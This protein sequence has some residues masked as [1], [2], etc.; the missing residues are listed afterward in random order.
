MPVEVDSAVESKDAELSPTP[1]LTSTARDSLRRS[2][3]A[4]GKRPWRP[5]VTP[6]QEVQTHK[7]DGSGTEED[8]FVVTW[9]PG[10][11]AEDPFEFGDNRK[12]FFLTLAGF[13]TMGVSMGSSIY[14]AGV[15]DIRKHLAGSD[16]DYILRGSPASE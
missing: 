15:F 4:L 7:F 3:K 14:S 16:T 12:W 9:L 8:P 11:D 13:S 6:W 5:Y 1:S 2:P 10:Q